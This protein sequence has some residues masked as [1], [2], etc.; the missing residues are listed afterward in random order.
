M[1]CIEEHPRF[2]Q[3]AVVET[4]AGLDSWPD[5]YRYIIDQARSLPR[6]PAAHRCAR[7]RVNTC[8][9]STWL[10]AEGTA[11]AMHF[12]GASDCP[13]DAG[14]LALLLRVY[15]GFSGE[16]IVA[17]PPD[18]LARSG[19]SERLTAHRLVGVYALAERIRGYA[20]DQL[21]REGAPVAA[22]GQAPLGMVQQSNAFRG[23]PIGRHVSVRPESF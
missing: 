4:L 20:L 2:A 10:R 19:L 3:Q 17:T 8:V 6:F 9:S 18:F 21:W 5:R 11:A 22:R 12:S 1:Q 7:Y 23:L 15:S 16:V 13:M 14:L